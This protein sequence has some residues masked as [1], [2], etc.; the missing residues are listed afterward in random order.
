MK[1][2][3][4][5]RDGQQ[6]TKRASRVKSP[7]GQFVNHLA[8]KPTVT[9]LTLI[10]GHY[11]AE[12]T[13]QTIEWRADEVLRVTL[14][15]PSIKVAIFNLLTCIAAVEHKGGFIN[16]PPGILPGMSSPEHVGP[17]GVARLARVFE[18]LFAPGAA[19]ATPNETKDLDALITK[20]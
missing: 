7:F 2:R 18:E 4:P 1:Q 8:V 15:Y 16:V 17:D 3:K 13:D 14:P 11:H 19:P 9:E 12:S 6:H 20:H 10:L 5:R